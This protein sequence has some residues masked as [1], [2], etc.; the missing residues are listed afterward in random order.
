MAPTSGHRD[1]S[2]RPQENIGSADWRDSPPDFRRAESYK[3]AFHP[4]ILHDTDED[5]VFEVEAGGDVTDEY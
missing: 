3:H 2:P 5:D 4:H 1:F